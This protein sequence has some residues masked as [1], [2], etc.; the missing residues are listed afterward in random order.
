MTMKGC[1]RSA[2]RSIS[3]N[4]L[5]S[6]LTTLGIIVGVAS[7]IVMVSIGSGARS[8]VDRLIASFGTNL[9]VVLPGPSRVHGRSGAQ[10]SAAPL[11]ER[12]LTAIKRRVASV[13]A[14]SGLLRGEVPVILGSRNRVTPIEGV[15]SDYFTARSLELESGRVF[16]PDE[17]RSGA[18]VALIG[19]TVVADLFEGSDPVGQTIRLR[20][21]PFRVV[22]TLQS[23]GQAGTSNDQDDVIVVPISTVRA[24]LIGRTAALTDVVGWIALKIDDETDLATAKA[25][26]EDVLRE[27]RGVRRD[28]QDNFVVRN[29]TEMLEARNSAKT[30]LGW[31]LAATSAVS[32]VVGGIGIMNI[33]L[34]SVGERT[35]EI[36]L[37][38][39]LGA[40]RYDILAQ[41]LVEAVVL[42]LIGGAIG[43]VLGIGFA[44][45]AAHIA[46]WPV[47][48]SPGAVL[49]ALVAAAAAGISFGFFPAWRAAHLDPI[50]ALRSE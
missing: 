7:V 34:V 50:D 30:T 22:G 9:L 4:L 16:E 38:L 42:C 46:V 25:A 29:L 15:H 28:M 20:N 12:D 24:R 5:R 35:R 39:A 27:A 36:G 45:V 43:V 44:I 11:T 19:K 40:R 17:M 32:L 33:M 10:G 13:A 6:F 1:L 3:A 26:V 18:R 21:I 47:V 41:F 14:I 2:I 37:R 48:L 8:D 31:L 49:I 23:K